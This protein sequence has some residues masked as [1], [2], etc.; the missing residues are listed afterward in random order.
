MSTLS[1]KDLTLL[2][3]AGE[4]QRIEFK[5]S[6]SSSAAKEMV[7]LANSEG[8]QILFGVDDGLMSNRLNKQGISQLQERYMSALSGSQ[9]AD[10]V[11]DQ[12]TD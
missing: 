7:A 3:T 4:G 5:R 1:D 8:G 6:V 2:L 9:T 10:Q 12:V 11:A